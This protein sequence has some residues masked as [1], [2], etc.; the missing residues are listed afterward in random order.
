MSTVYNA[1]LQDEK[2]IT[3]KKTIIEALRARLTT[4]QA[5]KPA[6]ESMKSQYEDLMKDVETTRGRELFYKFVP[7]G[8][9]NGA[10]IELADGS[11]KYDLITGIGV[12]FFGHGNLELFDAELDGAWSEV[13]QGNLGPSQEQIK[14]SKALLK[15]AGPKSNLKNVWITTCGAIANEIALK[16]IR[17]KK[18]PATKIFAFKDCFAGRTT[19]LQEI[20]DNPKYREGQPLYDEVVH[21]TFF[22]PKSPKSPAEQAQAVIQEMK[23]ALHKHPGAFAGIEFEIIQGEGGFTF[24]PK[25]FFRPIL[26]EAKKSGLAVWVDEIQT[27]GRTGEM[28]AFQKIGID[29]L[30]DVVTVAKLLQAAA[31]MY[32]A[33]YNP[34]AGLISGTF[35]SSTAGLRAGLK[36][37]ELLNSR[38]IG[39]KGRINHLA[40][41][42]EAEFARIKRSDAGKYLQDW[43]VVGGMIAFTLYD[44]TLDKT[45]KFLSKLWDNG[46][47]AFYCGHATI[48]A[49]MLPPFGVLTDE[50][51]KDVFVRIE[52][53][54]LEAAQELKL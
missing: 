13:M 27:F 44:G 2:F 28:F 49:R 20:T 24:G 11:I 48:R 12:N 50:Q 10:L 31:V 39:S 22:D 26:E 19:A 9:G 41:I 1:L 25:E 37:M 45:K 40:Q 42:A 3:A 43:T 36:T 35:S 33:E 54:I 5:P 18:S 38:M 23:G 46:A 30:V 32:T 6:L 53:S 21:L 47:I 7:S 14:L 17:Q 15:A 4:I 51:W 52:K 8:A 29:D 34:K 16:I